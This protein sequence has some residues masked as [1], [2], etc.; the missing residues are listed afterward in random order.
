MEEQLDLAPCGYLVMN[1]SF[2]VVEMNRTLRDMLGVEDTPVHLHDI[3][4][5]P[6]RIYFQT[7][8]AP[9]IM[10]HGKVN[11]MYLMLKGKEHH[12]PVLMNAVKHND[13]FACV[14]VQ[15]AVRDEYE[16]ELLLAR[17]K[18]ERILHDTD[19]ANRKLQELLKEVE[20]KQQELLDLNVEL[21]E[22]AMTDA[23]TGLKNRRFLEEKLMDLVELAESSENETF[24]LLLIDVDHFKQINDTFGHPMG[25]AVLRELSWKLL[26]ETREHDVVARMGGE[27]FMILLPS[28]NEESARVMAERIRLKLD[29]GSWTKK[30]VTVSI[31][32]TTY[33]KGNDSSIL[34]SKADAALYLSKGAGRNRVSVK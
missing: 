17:R 2:H 19:E 23:L 10:L 18:A 9:S 15:M 32:V 6:S 34:I 13:Q 16:N 20:G 8:F 28:T 33:E 31:G 30:R 25:D 7:Y 22:L 29:H 11:E 4:T 12:L 26:R 1:Q 21:Q 14:L 27:E 5:V 3:L 24:S